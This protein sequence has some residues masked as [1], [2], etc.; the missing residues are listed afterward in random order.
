M[1]KHIKTAI[2]VLLSVLMIAGA[3]SVVA[4]AQTFVNDETFTVGNADASTDGKT[5]G[6]DA[7]MIK[8]YLAG[9]TYALD[10]IGAY[11]AFGDNVYNS[12]YRSVPPVQWILLRIAVLRGVQRILICSG[13]NWISVL[14]EK[15][16][17]CA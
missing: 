9:K 3:L 4:A 11:L 7:Y 2:S 15:H 14:R 1:R 6:Q 12:V 5:N 16:C 13:G 17:L 8:S 10:V